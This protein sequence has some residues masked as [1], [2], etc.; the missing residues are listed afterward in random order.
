ME[1]A[2][3]VDVEPTTA[4]RQ[5]E[6]LAAKRM[7]ERAAKNFALHPSRLLG[8]SA[9]GSAEMLGWLVDEQGIE[10]HATVFDKAARKDGS[11][12]REDFSF[13]QAKDLYVC[14]GG[15]TLTT[16]GTRVNDGDT[17][18]YRASKAHCDA[19]ALRPRCCPSTPAR[20]VPRSIHEHARDMARE[21]AKSWPGRTSRRLRKKVEMLFAHL[22]RILKLDRLRL[23]GPNGAHDEFLL[24]QPL[25]ISG[26]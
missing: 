8:D 23:R 21:I 11:F 22:K 14:P 26:N 2:I 3:I 13:D 4:I 24:A 10:P 20:K 15:K 25:R 7:I 1:N 9:C 5:A 17:L 12:S 6:V 19:C 18:L 16:T